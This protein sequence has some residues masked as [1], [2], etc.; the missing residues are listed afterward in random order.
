MLSPGF[1]VID[2][3]YRH[4]HA[5]M[6]ARTTHATTRASATTRARAH[7]Q[8]TSTP[9]YGRV[10][11]RDRGALSLHLERRRHEAVEQHRHRHLLCTAN[12]ICPASV[13]HTHTR[14]IFWL[15]HKSTISSFNFQ[16]CIGQNLADAWAWEVDPARWQQEQDAS[17][18]AQSLQQ[19]WLLWPAQQQGKHII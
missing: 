12:T 10:R 6:Q 8:W 16:L 15:K 13:I 19:L 14:R 1:A 5:S 3:I 9:P 18:Q 4:T 11:R 7:I 17:S 2:K